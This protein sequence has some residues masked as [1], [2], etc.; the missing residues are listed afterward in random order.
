[1]LLASCLLASQ[2]RAADDE[3]AWLFEPDHVTQ[4]GLDLPTA[5]REALAEDPDEYVRG[6]VSLKRDDGTKYGPFV[7]GVKLKGH[8]SFRTLDGKAAFKLK[9][10]EFVKDQTFLGLEKLTLNNMVQDPTMLHELLA[11]E[12]FRA[13]GLPGWRT[14]Y[15]F[16]RVNGDAYGVYLNIETPDAVAL[17]RWY[18]TTQH[19]YEGELRVDL[20]PGGAEKYEVDEGDEGDLTDLEALIAAVQSWDNVDAVADLEELTRFWAVEKYVGHWDGYSGRDLTPN[21]YYLHSDDSGRFTM[22]PW[23]TD[24]TW[25]RR[26]GYSD[27]G[28][29]MFNRCLADLACE[30]LYRDAVEDVRATLGALAP[31]LHRLASD[32]AALLNPWQR[33]DPRRETTLEDMQDAIA[34]LLDFVDTRASDPPPWTSPEPPEVAPVP[35]EVS[36]VPPED[37]PTSDAMEGSTQPAPSDVASQPDGAASDGETDVGA[38][39]PALATPD[40]RPPVVAASLRASQKLGVVL[41]SG[42]RVQLRADE[43]ATFEVELLLGRRLAH[44]LELERRVGAATIEPAASGTRRATVKLSRAARRKLATQEKVRIIVSLRASDIAGNAAKG[45]TRTVTLEG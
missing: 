17:S 10:N 3:A 42:L 44:D 22:L 13:T 31:H 9:F 5:S 30:T 14:G 28:G 45:T 39:G 16:L 24:Q 43:P 21:N 34:A 25:E 29:V 27:P 1:M 40:T 2:V 12:A 6:T 18:P 8:G 38:G 35:P 20:V 4:I 15:S 26:L 7:V 41:K 33:I 37:P 32:T 11:Y 36:T 23:G 19:L